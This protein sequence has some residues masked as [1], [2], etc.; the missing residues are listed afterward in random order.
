MALLYVGT[1]SAKKQNK[2][3]GW[4]KELEEYEAWLKKHKVASSKKPLDMS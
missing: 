3:V 1:K 2:K 4:K